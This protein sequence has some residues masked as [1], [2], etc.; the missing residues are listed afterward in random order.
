MDREAK[1]A[2]Q[3]PGV[4]GGCLAEVTEPW[5]G[6]SMALHLIPPRRRFGEKWFARLPLPL[7]PGQSASPRS[8]IS[9][10]KSLTAKCHQAIDGGTR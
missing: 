6:R 1:Q 10:A 3:A 2:S 5:P 4:R 7:P 9:E 8:V